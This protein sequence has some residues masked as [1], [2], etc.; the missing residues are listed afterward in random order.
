MRK[1]Y[2]KLSLITNESITLTYEIS[3]QARTIFESMSRG[4]IEKGDMTIL[5]VLSCE[6]SLLQVEER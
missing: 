1:K 4:G 5:Y 2:T 3:S 6:E